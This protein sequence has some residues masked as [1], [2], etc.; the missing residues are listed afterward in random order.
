[1]RSSARELLGHFIN[2]MCCFWSLLKSCQSL[3]CYV[4]CCLQFSDIGQHVNCWDILFIVFA[5]QWKVVIMSVLHYVH[6]CCSSVKMVDMWIVGTFSQAEFVD[7]IQYW[8]KEIQMG[9]VHGVCGWDTIL[10]QEDTDGTCSWSLWMR[11]N[12]ER[13]SCLPTGRC[14]PL[15]QV[16]QSFQVSIMCEG[17]LVYVCPGLLVSGSYLTY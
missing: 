4:Y 17:V 5:L 15:N 3:L 9:H 14:M 1:M 11:Y 10:R 8:D 2:C 16:S 13:Y 12:T 6:C 7:E